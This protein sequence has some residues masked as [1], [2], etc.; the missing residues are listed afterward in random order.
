MKPL[1]VFAATLSFTIPFCASAQSMKPGLWEVS[2]KMQ[3][4]G[5]QME[6]EMAQMQQQMASMPPEQRKMIQDMMAKQGVSMGAGGPATMGIKVCMT[7]EMV[8]RNEIPEQPGDCKHTISSRS[9]NSMKVSL[10]CTNP[11]SSGEG[12]IT[13]AGSEAYTMKLNMTTVVQGK[14]EK[15]NMDGSG[16]WLAAE[17]G[18][19]KPV[20]IRSK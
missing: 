20:P 4:S 8:E 7:K 12:Q 9:G 19:I 1:H 2:N 17:C 18:A 16:R 3:A 11:P 13:F 15:V 10:S 14:T 5:G 6:R